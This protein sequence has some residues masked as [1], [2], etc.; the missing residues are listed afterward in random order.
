MR[1]G[2]WLLFGLLILTAPAAA[3]RALLVE[4]TFLTVDID[5]QTFRLE[6]LVA[7]EAGGERLPVALIT[8]GQ[9]ADREK[10]EKTEARSQLRL[11]RDFAR[12]GWLSVVVV[13]R[14][15][16]R[17]EG[18][19]PY[20]LPGCRDGDYG[21]VLKSQS[22]DLVAAITAIGK[23]ADAD[24]STVVAFGVSVGGATVLDLAAR[25][26]EGLKAVVNMSGGVRTVPRPDGKPLSCKQE[27]LIPVFA[28]LGERTR[29][30]TLWL[31][32]END[33]VFPPD[34][35]RKLHEA[36]VSKGGRAEFHMFEPIAEDGHFMV[37]RFDGMMR[38]LPALDRFLRDNKLKTWDPAPIDAVLG[39]LNLPPTARQVANRFGGRPTEKV[40]VL[41]PNN[42]VVHSTY[43]GRQMEEVEAKALEEC[44][45]VAKEPC[46][47]VLRNFEAVPA[48]KP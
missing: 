26:P 36:Y 9:S 18:A 34:F 39:P 8:H 1:A 7:K 35:V 23:R 13:R 10:R 43:G 20:M 33:K 11:A 14:G 19:R 2:L 5:G 27:D 22:D 3:E 37:N 15:F 17:S 12:R 21:A 47:T 41:S 30:P 28:S 24:I 46:R 38:W 42:R 40:L 44:A 48:A 31:Y 32:S 4:E 6:A 45:K 29:L 16:G 25:R